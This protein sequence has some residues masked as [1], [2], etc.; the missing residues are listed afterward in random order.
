MSNVSRG[1]EGSGGPRKQNTRSSKAAARQKVQNMRDFGLCALF[2]FYTQPS[3]YHTLNLL[4]M[5]LLLFESYTTRM[6][7]SLNKGKS[8]GGAR[9]QE[10]VE[11]PWTVRMGCFQSKPAAKEP[12][13]TAKEAPAAEAPV[14]TPAADTPS[15]EK[16]VEAAAPAE[17]AP[18]AAAP[19]T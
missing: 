19:A 18:H 4:N 1:G 12:S 9:R 16:S 2:G 13:S 6:P 5:C 10:I 8:Q 3:L 15:A 11:A 7:V 17:A 14:E